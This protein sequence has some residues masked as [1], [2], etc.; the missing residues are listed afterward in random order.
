LKK[1]LLWLALGMLIGGG[2]RKAPAPSA[3][4]EEP[5]AQILRHFEMQDLQAGVK[6]MTLKA[7]EGR[8]HEDEHSADLDEPLVTFYEKG[9]VSS[10][11]RAPHGR[12][13]TQTHAID[14][15]G[16]VTVVNDDSAT[17]TT[18]E[19]HYDPR[20]REIT[21][22]DT[23]KVDKPDSFTQGQGLVTDPELRNVRIGRQKVRFKKAAGGPS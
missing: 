20:L 18:D 5:S 19:L 2:C 13:D 11:M 3:S 21:S 12:V 16:G 14:A 1:S 22:T 9:A 23:V 7:L 17:L 6:S 4:G 15:W 10:V 8:L